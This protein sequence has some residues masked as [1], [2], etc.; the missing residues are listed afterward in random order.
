MA[1][2]PWNDDPDVAAMRPRRGPMP[3]GRVLIG[4]VLVGC[5]TF[6]LAYYLP[7]YRAHRSLSD[8]HS[9]LRGQ[10]ET[11]QGTL[12]KVQ[13]DLKSVTEKHDELAAERDKRESATKGKSAELAGVKS[14]LAAAL[15]KSVKKK[16]V[17]VGSDDSGVRVALSSAFLFTT[18]KVEPSGSGRAALCEVA[19]ASGSRPLRVVGVTGEVPALLK[20]KFPNSW[21]YTGAATASVAETLAEK[22]AVLPARISTEAP[23]APRPAGSAFGGET[24]AATRVEIVIS[25]PEAQKSP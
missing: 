15:E 22:C 14:A 23:G 18:G 2:N 11:A 5:G 13:S 25:A 12:G 21:A 20:L 8:D 19:K 10:L 24:P 4:V 16:Q 7:L 6:G 1:R 3:W 17:L 9:R